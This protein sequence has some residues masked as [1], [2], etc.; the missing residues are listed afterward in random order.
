[1]AF[2]EYQPVIG[3]S[4]IR[5]APVLFGEIFKIHGCVSDYSSLVVTQQDYAE[6][7]R[8]RKN[9]SVRNF[10]RISVSTPSFLSDTVPPTQTSVL[11][12][13]TLMRRSRDPDLPAR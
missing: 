11:F 4:I 7:M 13:P 5:D 6:F 3:Q 10:S 9:I 1:L 8:K 12:C 2:P